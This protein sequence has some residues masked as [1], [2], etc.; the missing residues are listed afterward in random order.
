MY[1][2]ICFVYEMCDWFINLDVCL[3]VNLENYFVVDLRIDTCVDL[4]I[5][6]DGVCF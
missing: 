1:P 5:I 2:Y 4:S 3:F 6:P